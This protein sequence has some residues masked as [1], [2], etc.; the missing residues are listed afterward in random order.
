MLTRLVRIQYGSLITAFF[1]VPRY[2]TE[3][4]GL[5]YRETDFLV[6]LGGELACV[7]TLVKV[8]RPVERRG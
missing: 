7:G 8:L 4:S 1:Y 6:M 5:G 3:H 2:M